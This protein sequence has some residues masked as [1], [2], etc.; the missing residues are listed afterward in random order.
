MQEVTPRQVAAKLVQ[1]ANSVLEQGGPA[2]WAAM[3]L[4]G[5]IHTVVQGA[6]FTETGTHH[7]ILILA[8]E[9]AYE[10][11]QKEAEA[12]ATTQPGLT[13]DRFVASSFLGGQERGLA[14]KR[15]LHAAL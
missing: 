15:Q 8:N 13:F 4:G 11:L 10:R 7:A 2:E 5:Q 1:H 6:T 12:E 3:S 14:I 9:L